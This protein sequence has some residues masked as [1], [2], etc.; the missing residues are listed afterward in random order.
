MSDGS[1]TSSSSSWRLIS[2]TLDRPHSSPYPADAEG[3]AL[4]RQLGPRAVTT[5]PPYGGT[6]PEMGYGRLLSQ[7]T[8]QRSV[9]SSD[10]TEM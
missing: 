9:V 3:L 6:V 2:A 5:F 1:T 7:P 4:D 8:I 10:S